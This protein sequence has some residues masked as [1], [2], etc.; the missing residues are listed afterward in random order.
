MKSALT[1]FRSLVFVWLTVAIS[2]IQSSLIDVGL[3][4]VYSN[5]NTSAPNTDQLVDLW[6]DVF[7][8]KSIPSASKFHRHNYNRISFEQ[9]GSERQLIALESEL[10]SNLF[11]GNADELRQAE[12]LAL[13]REKIGAGGGER[14]ESKNRGQK[15]SRADWF[16]EIG[17]SVSR[18]IT[19]EPHRKSARVDPIIPELVNF[20]AVKYAAER[21]SEHLDPQVR[22]WLTVS[23]LVKHSVFYIKYHDRLLELN[24]HV[25]NGIQ[26]EDWVGLFLD[27]KPGKV[28]EFFSQNKRNSAQS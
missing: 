9:F 16:K 8:L 24:W 28:S 3:S 23:S 14:E 10:D 21:S 1:V 22:V 5:V 25:D 6:P 11:N 13:G 15:K 27:F 18:R 19:A 20:S 2:E 26:T 4:A 7:Q 17:H 12:P